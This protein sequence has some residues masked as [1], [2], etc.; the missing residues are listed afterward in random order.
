MTKCSRGLKVGI[1]GGF[2]DV[3]AGGVH[4]LFAVLDE[5]RLVE[6]EDDVW[7]P[8]GALSIVVPCTTI[9]DSVAVVDL[10]RSSYYRALPPALVCV[11]RYLERQ[12]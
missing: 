8:R 5:H 10:G 1:V 12:G 6:H 2:Y 11:Q 9:V 4:T 3:E 7:D